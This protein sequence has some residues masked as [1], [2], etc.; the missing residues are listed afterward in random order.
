M[1]LDFYEWDEYVYMLSLFSFMNV[2]QL[3]ILN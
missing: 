1:F 3:F 2:L